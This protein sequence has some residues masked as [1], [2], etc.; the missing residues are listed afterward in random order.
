MQRGAGLFDYLTF[1]NIQEGRSKCIILFFLHL[2][3]L[4]ETD[5]ASLPLTQSTFNFLSNSKFQ[6]KKKKLSKTTIYILI[7]FFFNS[8]QMPTKQIKGSLLPFLSAISIL[9]PNLNKWFLRFDKNVGLYKRCNVWIMSLIFPLASMCWDS[10][11][12]LDL[13]VV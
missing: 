7:F 9:R 1:N 13:V 3:R 12:I 2:I 8:N 4:H 11:S 6:K 5:D 10:F